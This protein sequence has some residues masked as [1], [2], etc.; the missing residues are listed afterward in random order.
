[1]NVR[2]FNQ[3]RIRPTIRPRVD[4]RPKAKASSLSSS[5][6]AKQVTHYHIEQIDL[7]S[8]IGLYGQ[9]QI[10]QL[11]QMILAKEPIGVL[12]PSMREYFNIAHDLV[13]QLLAKQTEREIH[14]NN[15]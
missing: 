15:K 9:R 3:S 7:P 13:S 12:D 4:W 1:M 6:S 2:Y 10:M 11:M 14:G 5:A 8:D